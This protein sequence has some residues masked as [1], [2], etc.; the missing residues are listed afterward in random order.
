VFKASA[1]V[2]TNHQMAPLRE[3]HRPCLVVQSIKQRHSFHGNYF[4]GHFR[5]P[6]SRCFPNR[7][8]GSVRCGRRQHQAVVL[9]SAAS[10][11]VGCNEL[12]NERIN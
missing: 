6:E 10:V 3:N 2:R 8:P 11:V 5:T 4:V 1:L 7:A 9:Q 12:I